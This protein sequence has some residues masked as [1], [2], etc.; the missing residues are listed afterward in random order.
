[1]RINTC[2]S[3]FVWRGLCSDR[4]A[5]A[6]NRTPDARCHGPFTAPNAQ[7]GRPSVEGAPQSRSKGVWKPDWASVARRRWLGLRTWLEGAIP[8]LSHELV[9][10]RAVPGEAQP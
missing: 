7:A 8:S 5:R 6:N 1:M 3:T 2:S 10:L 9:E 4:P